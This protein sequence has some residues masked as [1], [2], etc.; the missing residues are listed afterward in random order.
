MTHA[1][2]PGLRVT[3]RAILRRERILP[4]KGDV[5]VKLGDRLQA[6]D[7]VAKTDLPGN[8]QTINVINILGIE[9]DE[10]R[11]FVKKKEGD[12]VEK[13]EV[14]AESKPL[15]GLSFLKTAVKSPT[16]GAIERISDVT[17]QVIIREPAMP[18]QVHAYVDG[19]VVEVRER[20]GVVMETRGGFVQGIFGIGGETDGPIEVVVDSTADVLDADRIKPEHKGKVVVGG[21]LITSAAFKAGQKAG[22]AG[23]VGGGFNDKDLKEILGYDLGVAITGAETVGLTLIVTEGFGAIKMADK[24]FALLKKSGGKKA[25]ISGAT[26]IRAG[27]IRPEVIVP[28]LATPRDAFL[29]RDVA[30]NEGMKAGD[31]IRVIREPYFGRV[32]RVKNLPHDLSV[33]ESETKVRILE[34]EFDDGTSAVVP[35]ANVET[36]ED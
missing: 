36:I 25:C 24:T 19:D 33:I 22:V 10:I 11:H 29:P 27:V 17:G 5:L 3:E 18:V 26:Q 32:G 14:I 12:P 35:R 16:K 8:V 31:I 13:D 1:Y 15:L 34:V 28:D 6:S 23:I 7:I 30:E 4:L 9:A 2:T 20:E 21:N